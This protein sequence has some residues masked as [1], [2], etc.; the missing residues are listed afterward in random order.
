MSSQFSFE[1][2]TAIDTEE[3]S[4]DVYNLRVA[5]DACFVAEG[6]VV[7]NCPHTVFTMPSVQMTPEECSEL[8]IGG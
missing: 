7:H 2:V 1:K 5:D 6:I 8:W 3:Y 4:G